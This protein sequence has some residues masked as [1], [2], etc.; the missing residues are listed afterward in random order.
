MYHGIIIGKV[1]QLQ[2]WPFSVNIVTL[3]KS[4]TQVPLLTKQYKL[5]TAK[6]GDAPKLGR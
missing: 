5:I 1:L 6:G 4:L 3:D 2:T